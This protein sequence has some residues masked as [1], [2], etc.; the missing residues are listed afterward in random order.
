M[1]IETNTEQST[2]EKINS[3]YEI[4]LLQEVIN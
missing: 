1:A 3:P 2:L 4:I